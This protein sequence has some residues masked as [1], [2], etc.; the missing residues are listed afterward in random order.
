LVRCYLRA[1]AQRDRAGLLAV[2][3]NIPPFRNTKADLAHSAD[4]CD[5]LATATFLPAAV[6]TTY[7]P[8]NVAYADGDRDRLALLNMIA[9]GGPSIWRMDGIGTD[10]TR[11]PPGPSPAS[12]P[13]TANGSR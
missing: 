6:D 12:G 2:A 7:V 8:V 9:M 13:A 1:L 3:A 10:V 5:E 11:G 4:A